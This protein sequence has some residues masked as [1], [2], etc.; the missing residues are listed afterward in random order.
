MSIT[1]LINSSKTMVSNPGSPLAQT[2][3]FR[4]QARQLASRLKELDRAELRALMHVSPKLAESTEALIAAWNT[5]PARQ[6]LAL[7]AFQ[8]DIYRGLVAATLSG[9]DRDYA[10]E[11]LR[12]LSGLYGMLR[13][14]DGIMPYRLELEYRL[15]GEGFQNLYEFWGDA[16]ARKLPRRGWI[17]NLA[18][19]EYFRAIEPFVDPARIIEPWF[20]SVMQPGDE[21]AFVAVHAK[22][23]RGAYARW[24]IQERITDPA[25]FCAFN[26]LGYR[27]DPVTSTLE[28]PVFV[29]RV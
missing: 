4:N 23:A 16:L 3:L 18:S 10:N 14:Y 28:K 22:V 27:F 5:R 15:G 19:Q 1:I 6:T 11:V 26:A 2:P 17:V 25:Q 9:E 8:G 21:P 13:P 7:D 12:M 29:K 24:L 20:L